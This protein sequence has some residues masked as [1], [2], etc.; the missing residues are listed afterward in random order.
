MNGIF[1]TS[2]VIMD[3]FIGLTVGRVH[4]HDHAFIPEDS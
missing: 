1:A 3:T 4:A 2:D